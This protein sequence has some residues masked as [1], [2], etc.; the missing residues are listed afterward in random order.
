MKPSVLFISF[1]LFYSTLC[2][3]QADRAPAASAISF[4]LGKTGLIYNLAFDHRFAKYNLGFRVVAG[5]NFSNNLQVL[6]AGGGAYYLVGRLRRFLE[7]GFDLQYMVVHERSD[8]QRG[9]PLVYPDYPTRAI[10]PSAN[11]G[12]RNYGKRTLFRIGFAPGVIDGN[13]VPGGYISY[14]LTF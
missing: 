1:L 8:D 5:N 11:I 6:T 7:L 13:L 4:E 3:S 9:F 12:Y 2:Q 14:G 10:Y